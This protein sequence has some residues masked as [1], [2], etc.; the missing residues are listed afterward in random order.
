[1]AN[2]IKCLYSY[3]IMQCIGLKDV[4]GKEIY[5]GDIVKVESYHSEFKN[6]TGQVIYSE[7]DAGYWII[8]GNKE[9]RFG[10]AINY[11]LNEYEVVGNIFENKELLD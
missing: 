5:E 9:N 7:I 10:I 2:S 1:M 4:N 11:E 3:E 6:I 8:E